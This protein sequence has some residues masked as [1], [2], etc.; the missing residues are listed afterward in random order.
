MPQS[1]FVDPARVRAKGELIFPAIPLNSYDK[2][3]ADE[4]G[5]YSDSELIGIYHDMRVIREFETMLYQVRTTKQYNGVD[6]VYTG[7]AHLYTGQE[8]AAVGMA[9]T[10]N[11]DDAIFGSHRSHGE[12]LARGYSMIRQLDDD[13]LLDIMKSFNNGRTLK[14]IESQGRSDVKYIAR[15]FL[16]YGFMA[17]LFGRENGFTK[18]LGNSMHVFFTPLG[19]YPNNAIVGGSAPI[20]VGAAL[21]KKIMKQ[22]GIVV[23]NAGDGSLGCGPVWEALNFAA[24]GQY[25][26][27]WEDE[28]KGGL[29][30]IFSFFN[31]GYGM[32]GQTD[33]ETMAYGILARVGAGIR[34]DALH[35]ERVDGYN[36]L[37][38]ID[39]Y[40]RKRQIIEKKK[41]PVLLDVVTYRYA[42]HSATDASSYRTKEEIDAWQAQDSIQAFKGE[43]IK[44]GVMKEDALSQID[45]SIKD[46]VTRIMRIAI[47]PAQSPRLDLER[48][49]DAVRRFIF[50]NER[51]EKLSGGVPDVLKPLEENIRVQKL[52]AKER[53]AFGKDGKAVSKLKQFTIRDGL[54]EAIIGKFYEDPTLI[55]FGEDNRDWGGAF[56]VYGGMTESLPY[57]RFFNSPIS[58]STIVSSAVGYAM[59][60]GRAIPELMYCDFLGRAGDEVFNQMAKWQAMSAGALKMPVVLRVSVGSKYGAQHAQDWSS[61]CTHIPGL[62]VCYPVTP[63][64]AK[65]LMNT[66]LNGSDPVV[67]FESQ[68]LYDMGEQFHEGGVPEGYYEIPFGEPDVKRAGTDM[69]ILSVGASLYAAM[70]AAKEL[71]AKYGVS[72]EVIDAR[73]LVPFNY[74]PVVES[75]KK[76]GRVVLVSDACERGSHMNDMARNITEFCFGW[77]DAPPT[78]VGAPN[79]ISPCPELEQYYYPQPEWLLSAIHTK[80]LPLK[81]YVPTMNYQTLEKTRREKL[82]I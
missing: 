53:F 26:S 75:V 11:K 41:G 27:L 21:Y 47:D 7:P 13:S 31:N 49:P 62:K 10:L 29:P 71:D 60:G 78:V 42:G 58:E 16:L 4:R 68:K 57:H 77:L 59:M 61:L 6:Y 1:Q 65:G 36:P 72:A 28:Y 80:L 19:I 51:I 22:K 17:E 9:Y 50:S 46:D 5:R 39:A 43:L 34:E 37:A 63:Y 18:G 74:D 52:K 23:C 81:G 38:V 64:D 67:F 44:N 45:Q 15:D 30:L 14:A 24:M 3:L 69:T 40:R 82:G 79:V 54:F 70:D 48:D 76:T 35:A 56:G 25:D 20:T 32:G 8:A 12:V 33:G 66:A 55:A 73:S 2:T